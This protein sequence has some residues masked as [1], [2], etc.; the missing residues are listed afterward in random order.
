MNDVFVHPS[1]PSS[2]WS[3]AAGA[4]IKGL[5]IIQNPSVRT[6]PRWNW[7]LMGGGGMPCMQMCVCVGSSSSSS[8]CVLK[9]TVRTLEVY[10]GSIEVWKILSCF[11]CVPWFILEKIEKKRPRKN[12]RCGRT[13]KSPHLKGGGGD[14]QNKTGSRLMM[15]SAEKVWYWLVL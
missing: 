9:K 4:L 5:L 11:T 2:G 6:N 8:A 10:S 14:G 12:F 15:E 7:N 13:E 3:A 1:S